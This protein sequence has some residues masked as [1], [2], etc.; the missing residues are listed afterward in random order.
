LDLVL[1]ARNFRLFY[2][3]AGVV[4]V[5]LATKVIPYEPFSIYYFTGTLGTAFLFLLHGIVAILL[6]FGYRTRIMTVICF[7]FAASLY[8]RNPLVVSYSDTLYRMLLF[9]AIFLPIGERWSVDSVHRDQDEGARR[10]F[11]GIASALILFQVVYMYL[12]NGYHRIGYELWR[13]GEGAAIV[14]GIDEMTFLLG[15]YLR[16]FPSLL[17]HGGRIW[18]YMLLFSWMLIVLTGKWRSIAVGS[19]ISVHAILAVTVRIGAF[20]YVA[21]S[22]L[23]LF[24]QRDFWDTAR[25]VPKIVGFDDQFVVWKQKTEDYCRSVARYFPDKRFPAPER[26]RDT[27]YSITMAALTLTLLAIILNVVL[28]QFLF[29]PPALLFNDVS[30]E[31]KEQA[32]ETIESSVFIQT[33]RAATDKLAISQPSW[34]IFVPPR[35]LDRYYVFTAKTEGG[36]VI[37]VFNNRPLSYKRPYKKLQKQYDT[38]RERFYMTEVDVA[39]QLYVEGEVREGVVR[40]L[41]EHV[42]EKWRERR[43]KTLTHV[44]IYRVSEKVTLDTIDSPSERHRTATQLYTHGCGDRNPKEIR[45]PTGKYVDELNYP[46]KYHVRRTR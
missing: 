25:Q 29:M 7:V 38:Y 31:P 6:V 21:I 20:S 18:L 43:G 40:G 19:F 28:A 12:I 3:E 46:S 32:E 26:I 23:V 9:W 42:C 35:T 45:P 17:V 13:T 30:F 24:L 41:L 4:P 34:D 1:R 2:T 44:N 37:D 33:V 14:M 11:T 39:S 16:S 10:S 15:D 36:E 22:G 8:H 5:T 27:V